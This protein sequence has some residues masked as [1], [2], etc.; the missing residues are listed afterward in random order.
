M[1]ADAAVI[2]AAVIAAAGVVLGEVVD[3]AVDSAD[4]VVAKFKT[5]PSVSFASKRFAKKSS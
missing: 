3:Q 5:Q 1:D 4:R 2:A